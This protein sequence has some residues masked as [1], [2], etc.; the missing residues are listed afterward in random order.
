MKILN[1]IATVALLF[2]M[3]VTAANAASGV[4]RQ[5]LAIAMY[6]SSLR[7]V[8]GGFVRVCT[9]TASGT[10]CTP[11]AHVY[12]D[13]G[14]TMEILPQGTVPV[15]AN[16]NYNYC[17][18]GTVGISYQEQITGS[19]LVTLT[20][21]NI[22]LMGSGTVSTSVA[23]AWSALQ[24]F[25]AGATI[26]GVLTTQN[27]LP[28]AAGTYNLGSTTFP[29]IG[30]IVGA[31]SA[32]NTTLQGTF[33]GLRVVT[34]PD[35]TLTV[36]GINLAQSWSMAN[37]CAAGCA[38]SRSGGGTIDASTLNSATF[39]APGAI[40]ATPSTINATAYT[41][42][43]L[44]SFVYLDQDFTT[45]NN[46][47]FQPITGSSNNLSWTMPA[48]TAM[49]L[50]FACHL[51]YSQATGAVS[52][53]FGLQDVTVAPT[54][55]LASGSM[56]TNTGVPSY[57]NVIITSTTATAIVTGTP[58]ATATTYNVDLSGLV[59]QP[60]NASTSAINIVVKTTTGADAITVKR[61]SY[62]RIN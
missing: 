16:G 13:P 60:S 56:E 50:P 4:C 1:K 42:N 35:A 2:L 49:V 62:C 28:S 31:T 61:D 25:N 40:G 23:N 22:I 9:E 5:G 55:L 44:A 14:L 30:V 46:T 53:S 26:N 59:E 12:S 21:D 57:G 8:T 15:D 52:D 24:T 58:N 51:V 48:T 33:T 27:V 11:L 32:H 37:I 6:G 18:D 29:Y 7:P 3:T 47:N 54:T 34:F 38:W 41:R 20:T 10:P 17:A 45:A 19:G 36:A 39:T 43:G